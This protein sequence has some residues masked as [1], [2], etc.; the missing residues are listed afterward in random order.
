MNQKQKMHASPTCSVHSKEEA[1]RS[2]RR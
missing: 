1:L 2:S